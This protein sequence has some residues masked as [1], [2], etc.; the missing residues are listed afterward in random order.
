MKN[1]CIQGATRFSLKQTDPGSS[2]FTSKR[3]KLI[4]NSSIKGGNI[5]MKKGV[6]KN[7]AHIIKKMKN[8]CLT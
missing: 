8:E 5:C 3:T 4:M 2:V 7:R 6:L 1:P